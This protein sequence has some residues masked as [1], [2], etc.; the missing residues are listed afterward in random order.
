MVSIWCEYQ[1]KICSQLFRQKLSTHHHR[2]HQ[3]TWFCRSLVLYSPSFGQQQWYEI[4]FTFGSLLATNEVLKG[5]SECF[6]DS[7]PTETF[8]EI[9]SLLDAK[10]LLVASQVNRFWNKHAQNEKLVCNIFLTKLILHSGN[11]YGDNNNCWYLLFAA[12]S[13]KYD[14]DLFH[15]KTIPFVAD[16]SYEGK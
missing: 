9:L 1:L 8:L 16:K 2:W 12:K 11:I 15:C 6:I 10:D 4:I 3:H 14:T 13:S 7:L 5:K